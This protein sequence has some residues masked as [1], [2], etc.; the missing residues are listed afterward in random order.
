[1][2]KNKLIDKLFLIIVSIQTILL[3]ILFIVQILRIFYGNEGNFSR[4]ICVKYILQILPVIILWILGIIISFVYFYIKGNPKKHISKISNITKLKNLERICPEIDEDLCEYT[5]IKKEKK[6]RKIAKIINIAIL[7]LCSIMGI[8]YMV[9]IKHFDSEGNLIAQAIQMSVHLLPWCII[10]LISLVVCTIYEEYSAN[11]SIELIKKIIKSKGKKTAVY[12]DD[13]RKKL[14]IN[15]ARGAIILVAV[16]FI[17]V[18]C[19][20]G[21]VK[22]VLRKA[23]NICTE[24][25]GL[26]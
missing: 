2:D 11:T 12:Y 6:K 17:I 10:S 4:E 14:A 22:D 25:I 21:G 16:V 18:G 13:R 19:F 15:I 23:V 3:G 8:L 9:N 26:G 5:F 20:D 24:C 1:M 7:V